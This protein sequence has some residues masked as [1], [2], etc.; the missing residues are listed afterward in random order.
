MSSLREFLNAYSRTGHVRLVT[1]TLN[2]LWQR[3]VRLAGLTPAALARVGRRADGRLRVA[4]PTADLR[5]VWSVVT[6]AAERAGR[7]SSELRLVVRVNPALVDLPAPAAQVTHVGTVSQ[8]VEFLH[9]VAGA[10]AGEAFADVQASA[11]SHGE[12]LEIAEALVTCLDR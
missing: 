8:V 2:V 12:F 4:L 5:A 1:S 7:D 10:G 6:Q 9:E 11:R 3:P